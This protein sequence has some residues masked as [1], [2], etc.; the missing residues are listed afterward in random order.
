MNKIAA[1]AWAGAFSIW[2][3]VAGADTWALQ[4]KL[5]FP[6]ASS[7]DAAID[8]TVVIKDEQIDAAG[9][10]AK[11]PAG[12]ITITDAGIILSGFVDLH[13][14]LPYNVFPRWSPLTKFNTRYEWQVTMEYETAVR[15]PSRELFKTHGCKAN[16]LAQIRALMSG[17]TSVAGSYTDSTGQVP[18]CVAGLIRNLDHKSAFADD[19]PSGQCL[20]K[21]ASNKDVPIGTPPAEPS[22]VASLVF[23]LETKLELLAWMRCMLKQKKLRSIVMH[24][25]E[26]R[27]TDPN[28]RREV[29]MM[30]SLGMLMEGVVV[31][32]GSALTDEEFNTMREQDVALVWSP[33]SNIDLY[34]ATVDF[35][36]VRKKVKDANGIERQITVAIAPDWSPNGSTGMLQELNFAASHFKGVT[37]GLTA[38][39]LVRMATS[40]AAKAARLGDK[41]GALVAG[42]TADMVVL[43]KRDGDPYEAVVA[44]SASDIRLVVV[45]GVPMYGDA[46]LMKTLLPNKKL[47]E[48]AVCNVKKALLL[49]GLPQGLKQ[50]ERE[51][52]EKLVELKSKLSD[53]ECR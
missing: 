1:C 10:D 37:E 39:T 43:R 16:M 8:G 20:E 9:K 53:F 34:G 7:A 15:G 18:T 3:S 22:I 4:G 31:V 24:L 45:G 11:A 29:R 41:I 46:D 14:H 44:S 25:A 50:L 6:D 17:T 33:R 32:H 13:N 28:G 49:E 19:A 2:S 48:M 27:P 51:L 38:Q 36:K 40:D 52:D 23:P 47:E 42:R 26:G 30:K 21:D 12:A 35:A 5:L